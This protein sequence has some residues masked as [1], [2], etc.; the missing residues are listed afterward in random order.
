MSY[1]AVSNVPDYG[2]G[3]GIDYDPIVFSGR[4]VEKFYKSTVFGEIALTAYEGEISGYGSQVTIRTVPDITISDYVIGDLAAAEYPESPSVILPINRGKSFN[5]AINTVQARQSDLDL[6]SIFSN[7]GSIRLKVAADGDML[8]NIYADVATANQGANAGLIAGDVNLGTVYAPLTITPDNVVDWLVYMGEV[9]DEQNVPNEGRWVVLPASIIARVKQSD[10]RIASLAG[11]NESILR[12]GRVGMIDRFR[13][14]MSNN[15]YQGTQ[16]ENYVMFGHP[17]G[18]AFA[19]QIT[20][21]EIV[22]NPNDFGYLCRGLMVYGYKVIAGNHI[23][24][25]VVVPGSSA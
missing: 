10:L 24:F 5:F 14:Y 3:G 13:V 19:A 11:D 25:S 9:L 22:Q 8:A 12:N 21:L 4:L 20:E 15:V 23:G 16:N 2:P 18:L 6:A 17:A 1:P 7:D